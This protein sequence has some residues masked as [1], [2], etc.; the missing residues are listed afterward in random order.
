MQKKLLAVV[1]AG[2]VAA[3]IF[4]PA[5]QAA[6][7]KK[8]TTTKK[9]TTTKA[10][11]A[12]AA[13]T[14]VA[15]APAP[16]AGALKTG[17]S[18]VN[19]GTFSSGDPTTAGDPGLS[20][21]VNESQ[22]ANM[23]F[24]GLMEIDYDTNELKP[25]VAEG[26]PTV[27]GTTLTFKIRKGVKFSNG[28]DVVPSSFKCS[29]DR[30]VGAALASPLTYHFDSI[31]GKKEVDDGKAKSIS[32]VIA[33]D[34]TMTLTVELLRPYADFIA[35]TQHTVFSPMTKAGC[36][37]GRT[38]H[39]GIM[40]GNGPFKMAEPW[41]RGQYIKM[42]RNE[43][44]WGGISGHKAYLDGVEFKIVKDEL[45]ALNVFESG[46]ADITGTVAGR[47]T[48]LTKKYGD[49]AAKKPQLVIQYFGFNWEDKVVGGFAN[50]KLRQAIS[51][52]V[53]RKRINDA[54]FDGSR[55]EATGFTPPGIAGTKIDAYGITATSNVALAK[56][57]LAEYGKDA[58]TIK[59]RIANTPANVNIASIIKNSVK[60]AIDVDLDIEADN[61]TGYFD[62][63][64]ANPGQAFRAGWAADFT[65]YDN[66]MYPLFSSESIGGDNLFKF[67]NAEV[68]GL[69]AEARRTA[70]ANKRNA[71]YQ[72]AE[73]VVL[74]QGIV[75]PLWWNKWS[76][77]LSAKVNAEA[78]AKAQGP[79]AFV[80]YNEVALK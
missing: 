59:L 44:Y 9:A 1:A 3:S 67:G 54:I 7:K 18:L 75:V 45:A 80:D 13:P 31:A 56:K 58:P 46:Q 23:L 12:T 76:T 27:N 71:L 66:F 38:Y 39:D 64:R 65:G 26:F 37:A 32:G 61:P 36:A 70:D 4:A 72:R 62:R 41:K 53:D 14:T 55:K 11:A 42:V 8:T 57:L 49:T 25:N 77:L 16:K 48:E 15:T 68:D 30:T 17:G 63:L 74:G 79:T 47:F 28:E 20:S 78:Y 29:W 10:P 19:V 21:V 22:I 60:T 35:E 5:A 2:A 40:I 69:I 73:A 52:A 6:T 43:D 50:A 33:N 34:G 24:D 51:L